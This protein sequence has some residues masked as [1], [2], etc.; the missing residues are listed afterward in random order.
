MIFV[1]D[2]GGVLSDIDVQGFL[3]RLQRLMPEGR[4]TKLNADELLAGGGDSFLHDYELGYL[5]TEEVIHRFHLFCRPEVTD[6]QIR[7]IWLSELKPI[8]ENRKALLRQLRANGHTVCLLSNTND[9]HW[10]YIEPM[11]RYDSYTLK[12]HFDH[13]F[14]SFRLHLYKPEKPIFEEVNKTIDD[15]RYVIYIDDAERNRM[16]GQAMGWATFA[17][18][19][20]WA[21]YE[22]FNLFT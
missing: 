5:S 20:E 3:E 7:Q 21:D 4:R 2:L 12:D 19:R 9:M 22:K 14:L 16:A 11:F 1:F 18:I 13:V 15:N 8:P 17:S 6:E 10:Q